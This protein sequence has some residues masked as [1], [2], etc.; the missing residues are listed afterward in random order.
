MI[1]RVC[2]YVKF[3]IR[4]VDYKNIA[5][6]R[7]R[8]AIRLESKRTYTTGLFILDLEHMPHGCGVWPAF[9]TCGAN[10]PNNG[11]ID[12]IENVH[13]ATVNQQTL[14]TGAG[15]SEATESTSLFSGYW[16][17]SNCNVYETGNS[18]CGIVGNKDSYGIPFNNH[19]GGV[20]AMEWTNSRIQIFFFPRGSI[21][22]N[23]YASNPDPSSWGK[24][25]GYWTLGSNCPPS[26][27]NAH[28]IIFDTTFCGD[29]AGATFS[30]ACP[31]YASQSCDSF[32]Q[33]N[34]SYFQDAYWLVNGLKIYAEDSAPSTS[35]S[36][37]NVDPWSSGTY[38]SCCEGLQSC[39]NDWNG[40]N[41]WYYLC[42][43]SCSDT[44]SGVCTNEG[45]DPWATGSYVSCCSGLQSCLKDW[46]NNGNYFYLCEKYC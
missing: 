23:V 6:G 43:S 37:S 24:P 7:G 18:G 10:W 8:N 42:K 11:E 27:F 5:S 4:G 12:V 16:A 41:N 38:V 31:Q 25:V 21:P 20:Y 1:S 14:H 28:Q 36:S 33:T 22:A 15:C 29:W 46:K 44:P 32:V 45:V 40:N 3:N 19:Q 17:N 39:L 34:P 35:C 13:D 2:A 26:H 9:W 30:S